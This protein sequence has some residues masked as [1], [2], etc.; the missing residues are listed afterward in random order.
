MS[1]TE[2]VKVVVR[3]RPMNA[4]EKQKH[5][6][7]CIQVDKPTNQVLLNKL[8]KENNPISKTFTYDS[9]YGEDST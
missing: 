8:D 1:D 4:S 2:S 3:C 5:C 6:Q 9:V 7:S